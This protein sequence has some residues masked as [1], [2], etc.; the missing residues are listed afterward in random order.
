[1]GRGVTVSGIDGTGGQGSGSKGRRSHDAK[2]Q[3]NFT[4]GLTHLAHFEKQVQGSDEQAEAL[5]WIFDLMQKRIS[6]WLFPKKPPAD[7]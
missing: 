4:R 6:V 3:G 5:L 2:V 1:M 7:Q